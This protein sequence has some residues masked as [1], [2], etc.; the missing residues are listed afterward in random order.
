MNARRISGAAP[1]DDDLPLR[2]GAPRP[3]KDLAEESD[4]SVHGQ[5][6]CLLCVAYV[7]GVSHPSIR[8]ARK[9]VQR[10]KVGLHGARSA[11]SGHTNVSRGRFDEIEPVS[12][13]ECPSARDAGRTDCAVTSSLRLVGSVLAEPLL[14]CEPLPLRGWTV[15]G[16][17][18]M[19]L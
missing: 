7:S 8:S 16:C 3:G 17:L 18:R 12:P 4:S 5:P 10:P 6:T 9:A 11:M 1:I 2:I 14:P 15:G 13:V 19:D